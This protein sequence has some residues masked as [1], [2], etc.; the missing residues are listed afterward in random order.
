[1][2]LQNIEVLI[3]GILICLALSTYVSPSPSELLDDIYIF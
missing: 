1:M 3:N 2:Y